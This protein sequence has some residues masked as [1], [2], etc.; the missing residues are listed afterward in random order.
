MM[1]KWLVGLAWPAISRI[2]G[3]LGIGTVTFLG[4]DALLSSAVS[5]AQASIQGLAPDVLALLSMAGFLQA[6]SITSGAMVTCLG[7]I[8][9]KRFRLSTGT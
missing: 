1:G 4:L 2:L 8:A 5:Q 7:L 9:L 3:A 6:F